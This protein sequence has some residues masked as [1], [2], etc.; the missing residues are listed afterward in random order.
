MA[1]AAV[2]S[3]GLLSGCAEDAQP[4]VDT[5]TSSSADPKPTRAASEPS[6]DSLASSSEDTDEEGESEEGGEGRAGSSAAG[7]ASA[8]LDE[9]TVKGR[10]PKTGY[11]GDLFKWRSDTDHNGCDTRNDVLRRDLM[12]ITLKAG[13]RGCIVLAGTLADP[14]AGE[15]YDF[16]R[17]ANAVD[18]DHV[19]ARSNAW[20]TGAFEFDEETLKE[21]GNDPLNLLAVSSSLNRQ[22]GDG[23]AATWLPPNKTFRCEYVARQIAVKHKYDLWVVPPEKAAMERVLDTCDDQ[24]TFAEDVDWPG[25]GDGD[26]VTTKEETR[27]AGQKSSSSGSSSSGSSSSSSDSSS[28]YFEN[29]TAAREAGAAPVRRGDAGYGSHLDRDGDGIACE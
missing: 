21:F 6:A 4:T 20:Q 16:D 11:D 19:V 12:S 1:L 15:T 10:A 27:P 24:P 18:I 2:L 23:D 29:C 8:M 13:T 3:L 5:A 17:S 26:N 25:P 22:K 9:L 7:T 14:Y 28:T